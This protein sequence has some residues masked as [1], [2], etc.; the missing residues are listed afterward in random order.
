MVE[1]GVE[2]CVD[3]LEGVGETLGVIWLVVGIDVM[4]IEPQ[5]TT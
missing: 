2:D 3:A 1:D 4:A 5:R